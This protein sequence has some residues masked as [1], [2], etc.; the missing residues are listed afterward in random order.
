MTYYLALDPGGTTGWRGYDTARHQFHDGI[1]GPGPH[2]QQLWDLLE[3]MMPHTLI[4]ES[5]Q[6]TQLKSTELISVE[7]IGIAKLWAARDI[8][9]HLHMYTSAQGKGFWTDDKLVLIAAWSPN[10]HIRDATRHLLHYITFEVGDHHFIQQL[11][12]G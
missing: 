6:H 9:R 5:F 1:C 7:Y 12:H 2:H 4:C 11:R 10:R 8:S 3:T